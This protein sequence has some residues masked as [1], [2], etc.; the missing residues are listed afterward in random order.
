[1]NFKKEDEYESVIVAREKVL[2]RIEA[3]L[4]RFLDGLAVTPVPFHMAVGAPRA[5]RPSKRTVQWVFPDQRPERMLQWGESVLFLTAAQFFRVLSYVYA[6]LASDLTLTKRCVFADSADAEI[7]TI[8]TLC[9]SKI[10][11]QLM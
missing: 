10:N 5:R 3:F 9:C 1:M 8:D 2:E 4:G 7:F 6:A 11:V